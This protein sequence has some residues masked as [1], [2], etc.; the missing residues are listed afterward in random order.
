MAVAQTEEVHVAFERVG[1]CLVAGR[2]H[3]SNRSVPIA[4]CVGTP[5]RYTSAGM[6]MVA[7]ATALKAAENP[8]D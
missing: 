4:T 3:P 7:H 8:A 1:D 2:D 6:R 5:S